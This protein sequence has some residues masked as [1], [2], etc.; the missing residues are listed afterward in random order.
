MRSLAAAV[1]TALASRQIQLRKFFTITARDRGTGNP[2][3]AY[4]W[5]DLGSITAD[6][7]DGV[8]G[9]TVSRTFTG[10][11]SLIT[12]SELPLTA[13]LTVRQFTVALNH[14]NATID[15][16]VRGYDLKNA[17]VEVHFGLFD[18]ATHTLVAALF[19]VAVGYVDSAPIQTP[20]P[21]QTGIVPLHCVSHTRELT[22]PSYS[23]RSHEDQKKRNA[24]DDFF[25][26]GSIIG[27][28][29]LFW[30]MEKIGQAAASGTVVVPQGRAGRGILGVR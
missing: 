12:V 3:S 27:S 10:S 26:Y 2:V 17:Y 24:S 9:N 14:T 1:T 19:P 16:Y 23:V 4:F 13:D 7:I 25:K 15:N 22:R 29:E 8:T 21:N 11:G 18:P 6:T 28:V 5:N 20:T 30:N